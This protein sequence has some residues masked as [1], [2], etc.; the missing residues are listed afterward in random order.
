MSVIVHIGLSWLFQNL[1][2]R[3]STRDIGLLNLHHN[4][5]HNPLCGCSHW[6]NK[7]WGD[8][9][10][11]LPNDWRQVATVFIPII[12]FLGVIWQYGPFSGFIQWKMC[13]FAS[14]FQ[15]AVRPD[16][17]YGMYVKHA[18]AKILED[19]TNSERNNQKYTQEQGQSKILV[20]VSWI[21]IPQHNLTHLRNS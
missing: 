16:W 10:G 21:Q 7:K 12:N 6:E 5:H 14:C 18:A 11:R 20:M 13:H 9:I 19:I 8:H 4:L 1:L 15:S 2:Y 3:K 17:L